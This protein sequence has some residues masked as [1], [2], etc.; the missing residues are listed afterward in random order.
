MDPRRAN[1][2]LHQRAVATHR[3]VARLDVARTKPT[4]AQWEVLFA[5]ADAGRLPSG[6]LTTAGA[7]VHVHAADALVRVGLA[8]KDERGY[9]ELTEH[10]ARRAKA[11]L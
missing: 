9:Y 7:H 1:V 2:T 3:R 10:G 4:V 5:L 6:G 11:R 8:M